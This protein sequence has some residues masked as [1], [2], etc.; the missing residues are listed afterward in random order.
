MREPAQAISGRA[1][2]AWPSSP[3]GAGQRRGSSSLRTAEQ[4]GHFHAQHR[5]GTPKSLHDHE[6]EPAP[7]PADQSSGI[8]HREESPMASKS[9]Y[10]GNLPYDVTEQDLR[11]LFEPWGPVAETRLIASRG[12]GFVEV[13]AEKSA[14]AITAMNGK[15]YKGRAL[16]VNEA[17]PRS[18]RSP[19][20]DRD[21]G[22]G[23]RPRGGGPPRG[24]GGRPRGGGLPERSGVGGDRGARGWRPGRLY[25]PAP[26]GHSNSGVLIGF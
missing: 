8:T 15:E 25:L 24:G 10:V 26:K 12:F 3:T 14:D 5:C 9:L 21:G 18:E 11:T 19:F 2:T 13:P 23:G 22:G 16:V 4:N 20:R 7:A 17:R 6:T 1:G